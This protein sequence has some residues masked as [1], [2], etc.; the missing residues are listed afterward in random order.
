[1]FVEGHW[2]VIK[3]DFLYKFFQ[4]RLDLVIYILMEKVVIHQQRKLQQIQIGREKP[5][6]I[7]DFKFEWKKLSKREINNMYAT[8]VT[9]W[10]CGCSYY[11]TSRFNICK[12][13]VYLK[14]SVTPEFFNNVKRNFQ[15][16]FLVENN[17]S[18]NAENKENINFNDNYY[19][20][21]TDDEF[22]ENIFDNLINTTRKALSL[23]E[24]QKSI[25]NVKWCKAVKKSFDPITKLVEDVEKYRRKRTMP[26]TWKGHTN[27]TRYLK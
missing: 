7:K 20:S 6:W 16:P 5:E 13:L 18:I 17:L 1:M 3:R 14:G 2:K 26:L 10:I 25:G 23:V 24:E 19:D 8:N 4:P 12:H 11:L 9:Q 22:D 27:N 21:S 15:P